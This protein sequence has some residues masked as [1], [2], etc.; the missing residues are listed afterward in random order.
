M[1][2]VVQRVKNAKVEVENKVVG[3]IGT[4]YMVL[5]GIGPEDSEKEADY[6]A[7]KLI[8]LRV[9]EDE[10]G[11]MNL[12]IKQVGGELLIISQFTLYADCSHGNRPSFIGAAKPEKANELYE[13]F[14]KKC[15]E[16]V[17]VEK[18][19]FGAHMEVSLQNS[20]PVTI[21]LKNYNL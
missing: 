14:C 18:G 12:N 1:K 4:G 3:K 6:L 15:S 11:K 16:E 2:L 13:Y 8:N 17:H 19:I 9:F 7:K 21:E 5:I 20:G 10:K